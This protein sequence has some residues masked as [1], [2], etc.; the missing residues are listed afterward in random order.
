LL[1]TDTTCRRLII[2]GVGYR[3]DFDA[4]SHRNV[5]RD[6]DIKP[7]IGAVVALCAAQSGYRLVLVS[8]TAQKLENIRSSIIEIVPSA[9]IDL[10]PVDLL[11]PDDVKKCVSLLQN[12]CEIDLV[13][14]A[15]LGA[16]TYQLPGDNPYLEIGE[17]PVELPSLE[18]ES[19]VRSLLIQVQCLLPRWRKQKQSR[20][21]VISSMS[22]IRAVPFGYS[23]SS[24][25]AGLHHAVRSMSL[26]LNPLGIRV[27]EVLPG[28]VN[29]GMYD[30]PLV[31]SAIRKM[32]R[33]FGYE[34]EQG[35]LPQ[36]DPMA[37]AEAVL[38]CLN[39]TA[40]IL[41]ISLVA[42]GQFPFHGS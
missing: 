7:N 33:S 13:H 1:H 14:S 19:V 41:Q 34:Y 29:T 21:V 11:N 26:E 30:P 42:D 37:V 8:R 32:G 35:K 4:V 10:W 18:F 24:A 5:Y 6:V 27:S 40:H 20:I 22:G 17:T 25:K 15:G 36:M 39:T 38:L 3:S 28:I 9:Q 16:G 31:D 12:D 2:T 23:H